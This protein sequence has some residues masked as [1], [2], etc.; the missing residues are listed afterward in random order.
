M[1]GLTKNKLLKILQLKQFD[2]LLKDDIIAIFD[3]F[4]D[5]YY[6]NRDNGEY[7]LVYENDNFK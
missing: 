5:D 4:G 1:K 7:E 2:Y 6:I 3:I